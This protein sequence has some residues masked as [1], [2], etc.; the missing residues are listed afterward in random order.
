MRLYRYIKRNP[1]KFE[2]KLAYLINNPHFKKDVRAV[3]KQ[4]GLIGKVNRNDKME[5]LL[6]D[7]NFDSA[8]TSIIGTN[9]L[10]ESYR[11]WLYRYIVYKDT[12]NTFDPD[13]SIIV[14]DTESFFI[15]ILPVTTLAETKRAFEVIKKLQ[16][17]DKSRF[18]L[19]NNLKRDEEIIKLFNQDQSVNAIHRK[20]LKMGHDLDFGNIKTIVSRMNKKMGNKNP[21]KLKTERIYI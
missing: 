17:K 18:R 6:W 2:E 4:H 16:Y 5:F 13:A 21:K 3:R 10:S 19:K 14:Q 15:K 11:D 12:S 1:K 9:N 7:T 20:M 8:V